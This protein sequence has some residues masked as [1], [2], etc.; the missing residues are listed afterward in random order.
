MPCYPHPP[1]YPSTK[2]AITAESSVQ[3]ALGELTFESEAADRLRGELRSANRQ[4][5]QLQQQLQESAGQLQAAEE[6][7]AQAR[8]LAAD[9]SHGT[10]EQQRSEKQLQVELL[11]LQ[12]QKSPRLVELRYFSFNSTAHPLLLSPPTRC[13]HPT[14]LVAPFY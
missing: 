4:V 7:A 9:A 5:A 8:Q 6:A 12:L 14:P 3:A 11:L 13:I 2:S 1:L 10:E